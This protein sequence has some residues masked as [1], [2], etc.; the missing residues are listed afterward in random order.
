MGGA[1]LK[2]LE[3]MFQG[4]YKGQNPDRTGKGGMLVAAAKNIDFAKNNCAL[5]IS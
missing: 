1:A 2:L 3:G 4:R 5:L